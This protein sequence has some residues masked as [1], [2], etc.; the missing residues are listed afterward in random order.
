MGLGL[1]AGR[2][3]GKVRAGEQRLIRG[4]AGAVSSAG[5]RCHDLPA[6]RG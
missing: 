3:A 2:A 1:A 6:A 4:G 5:R